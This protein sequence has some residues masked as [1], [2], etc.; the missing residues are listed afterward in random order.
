M[1]EIGSF[2]LNCIPATVVASRRRHALMAD[3]LLHRRQ[4]GAGVTLSRRKR[5]NACRAG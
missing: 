3:H 2:T 4:V 1:H 5:S